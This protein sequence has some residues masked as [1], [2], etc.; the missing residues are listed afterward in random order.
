MTSHHNK[1]NKNENV[2][3]IVGITKCD[4]E[5]RSNMKMLLEPWR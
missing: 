1:Y 2:L 3:N 5:T 4:T